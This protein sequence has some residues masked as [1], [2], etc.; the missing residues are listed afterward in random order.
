MVKLTDEISCMIQQH[1][2]CNRIEYIAL[3]SVIGRL[4]RTVKMLEAAVPVD[5]TEPCKVFGG[6]YS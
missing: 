6:I 4:V 5:I 2:V 3:F 1:S